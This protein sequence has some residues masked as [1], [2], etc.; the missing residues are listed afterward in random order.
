VVGTS[1]PLEEGVED[2]Q[3]IYSRTLASGWVAGTGGGSAVLGEPGF[4]LIEIETPAATRASDDGPW[5]E[6]PPG[7]VAHSLLA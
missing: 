2:R 3:H 4:D 7:L 6:A 5:A 1:Q